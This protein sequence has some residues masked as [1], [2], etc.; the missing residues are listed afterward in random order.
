M[1][2]LWNA[3]EQPG[4]ST[5]HSLVS[6]PRLVVRYAMIAAPLAWFRGLTIG[7]KFMFSFGI[8][9]VVLALSLAAILVYLARINGYIERHH[10]ITVPVL[11]TMVGMQERVSKMNLI[12]QTF[13]D[14]QSADQ[15]D[16]TLQ[17]LGMMELDTRNTFE[18]YRATYAARTHPVLFR[19]L[20]EH[21]QAD[22]ADQEDVALNHIAGLLEELTVLRKILAKQLEA[23]HQADAR[24]TLT[25]SDGLSRQLTDKLTTIVNLH[26]KITAE[27]KA[28]GDSLLS[29]AKLVILALVILLGAL[30]VA[31]Y[32][33]VSTQ[34]A[35][36][37]RRLADMADR[38]AHHD[39]SAGFD[40]WPARDEV[41]NLARSL[42]T[43]LSTMRERALALERKT[44]ELEGFTYSVAHDLKGPL[45]EIEGFSS[46]IEQ[47]FA[48]TLEP[49]A[50]KYVAAIRSSALKLTALINALLRYSR[51]EQQNLP[52]DWIN[53]RTLVEHLVADCLLAAGETPPRISIDLPC[54][55]IWGEPTSIR[56]ALSNLL[57][58]A[59]KFSRGAHPPEVMIGGAVHQDEHVL[60]IR[61]NG[62][63]FD[64]KAADRIFGLFQRLHGHDEYEGT[65]VGL[66]IV[67]LV[68][69]KHRGRVWVES[70]PGKGST[71]YLAFPTPSD[72]QE[73]A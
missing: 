30:I 49:T 24:L 57:D 23:G 34:I 40:P 31:T 33:T 19:M 67:K 58:N 72:N 2:P 35:S 59:L 45:R 17:R 43:M 22:L 38:V 10:R 73:L 14:Q 29:Q 3:T 4:P 26:T 47:K 42:Q 62:I 25:K 5:T 18:L 51:L 32:I 53:L 61:D 64:Q 7:Q 36:P 46:L 55:A 16:A 63:G 11:V 39:L 20:T 6:L 70:S 71:F 68:M 8:M 50:R 52:K 9:L 66:A 44:H 27:M 1:S 21:G 28:E 12:L 48:D 41:G 54:T 37:L 60:W 13:L 15:R 69:E 65:G 56:Q